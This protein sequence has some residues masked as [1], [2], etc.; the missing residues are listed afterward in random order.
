MG[1]R[2]VRIFRIDFEMM[3]KTL[4]LLLA[5]LCGAMTAS[6]QDLIVRR[7][8][9]KVE[10]NVLEISTEA[11]RYK[12]YS[13]PEGPTYIVPVKD[14]AYIR[15]A[16]GETERYAVPAEVAP[17]ARS[18][19]A[20]PTARRYEI[21]DLYEADGVRGIV[22]MVSEDGMH[23]LALSLDE[24]YLPWS[25]FRKPGLRVVGATDRGDGRVN[26]RIVE[27]YIAAN[28]L[29]WDDFPAFK[30]CREK[31]EG[32]YLPSIDELLNIG[33]NYNGGS[34]AAYN[35]KAQKFFNERLKAAGGKRMDR[36]VN[37]F[38]ST[39]VNE[40]NAYTSH[41]N[42]EPPYVVEIQKYGKF[43]VRAVHAF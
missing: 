3:R 24:I 25:G 8:S 14:L 34:R 18:A 1:G 27:E 37:Y 4:L 28:G 20:A 40:R 9:T 21:G 17:A 16:N 6:A 2:R 12:K 10:A 22:C 5:A 36:L 23:G 39:E 35:R 33:H 41:M 7:D 31:G 32:W 11:V 13:Y 19:E 30:W 43:L 15:Y 42:I 29:S 26:M 38:S